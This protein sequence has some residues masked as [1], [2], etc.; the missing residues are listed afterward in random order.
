[1]FPPRELFWIC[2]TDIPDDIDIDEDDEEPD[3]RSSPRVG[4]GD[5]D[6][7]DTEADGVGAGAA[8]TGLAG[9]MGGVSSPGAD[10]AT[11][12][13]EAAGGSAPSPAA[14]ACVRGILPPHREQNRASRGMALSQ[15]GQRICSLTPGLARR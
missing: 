4:A 14:V 3:A 12:G 10:G 15:K 11:G 2:E 8:L 5:I 6:G 1:M 13:G 9:G 7:V